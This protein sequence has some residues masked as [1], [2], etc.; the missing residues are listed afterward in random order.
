MKWIELKEEDQID[1]IKE[2]SKESPLLIY[3]HSTRCSISAMT[4][5]RLERSWNDEEMSKVKP[6]F[7]DLIRFRSLSNKIASEFNVH[8]ESPQVLL[9]KDEKCF[10]HESHSGIIYKEIT[11]QLLSKN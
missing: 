1:S 10:Y 3:K 6:Y 4:L 7:L 5:D 8:H 9:I 11:K 2:Q